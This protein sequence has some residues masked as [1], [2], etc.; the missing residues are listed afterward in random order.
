MA[1][2]V[3]YGYHPG[4]IATEID[5]F[6]MKNVR[7]ILHIQVVQFGRDGVFP[8]FSHIAKDSQVLLIIAYLEVVN[9]QS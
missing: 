8:F 5:S 1:V 6:D 2:K 7:K 9:H 4:G 3:V